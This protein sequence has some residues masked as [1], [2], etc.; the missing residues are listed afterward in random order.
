MRKQLTGLTVLAFFALPSM[1]QTAFFSEADSVGGGA[2]ISNPA[3]LQ[4]ATEGVGSLFLWASDDARVNTTFA[5]DVDLLAG[6]GVI[7][8]AGVVVFAPTGRW[9]TVSSGT[10]SA[11]AITDING[12][13]LNFGLGPYGLD[14]ANP[15]ALYD[16]DANAFLFARIDYNILSEGTATLGL[17]EGDTLIVDGVDQVPFSYGT[18]QITV[19]PEPSTA[20]LLLGLAGLAMRRQ[21]R[22]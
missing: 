19:V 12:L 3:I 4:D 8:L 14:T 18:A 16:A 15:D 21:R 6:S 9:S 7:E 20:L 1:G 13:A 2:T 17:S 22:Y 11:D 5:L 10:A